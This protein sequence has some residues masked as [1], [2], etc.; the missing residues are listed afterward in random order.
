MDSYR[1]VFDAGR[2]IEQQYCRNCG[3]A[4]TWT[5]EFLPD[6]RGI[7]AGTFD[8]PDFPGEPQRYVFA[9]TKPDWL[10]IE[11]DMEV[12]QAMAGGSAD[13]VRSD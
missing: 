12:C 13:A 5:L 9:R 1:L 10:G 6:F 7:A 4:L 11:S 2:W 3:T 8:D